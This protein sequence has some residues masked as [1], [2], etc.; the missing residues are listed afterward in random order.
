MI[1]YLHMCAMYRYYVIFSH[2]VPL[3]TVC[4]TESMSTSTSW[5]DFFDFSGAGFY[6]NEVGGLRHKLTVYV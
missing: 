4:P 6:A 1:V 3:N 2:R 5:Q